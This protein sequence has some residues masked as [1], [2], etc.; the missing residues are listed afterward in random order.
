MNERAPQLMPI[1]GAIFE[2]TG[3]AIHVAMTIMAQEARED[4]PLRKALIRMLRDIKLSEPLRWWLQEL[5]G[6]KS[7]TVD[8]GGL[9]GYEVRA[10]CAMVI[11]AIRSRLPKPEMWA[12]Q[13]KYGVTEY[14]D[15][16]FVHSPIPNSGRPIGPSRRRFAFSRE[17]IEAIRNLAEWLFA[18]MQERGPVP[19][20]ILVLDCM[21]AKFYAHHK[22]TTIS[23]RELAHA[24]GGSHMMYARLMGK[25]GK[26]LQDIEQ[27][28]MNTLQ[29]YFEERGVVPRMQQFDER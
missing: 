21:V 2:N 18:N 23:Y 16:D 19:A 14:E 15:M 17:K 12:L 28:A 27:R 20:N 13:A 7:G 22:K 5:E 25:I 6:T 8:F 9:D 3:Q 26:R 4:G 10:Q 11:S 1:A 24:F 29:P